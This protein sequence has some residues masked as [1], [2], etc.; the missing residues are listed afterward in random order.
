MQEAT[1][2]ALQGV[3]MTLTNIAAAIRE[4]GIE[5]VASGDHIAIIKHYNDLRQVNAI[6]KTAREALTEI[7]EKFS[8][9]Y[10]PDTMRA[11]GIKTIHLEGIGRVTINH[12]WSASMLDKERGMQWLRDTDN[13][14]LIIETVNS[15]TLASFAREK[16]EEEGV[17]LPNDIFKVG[18]MAYTSITKA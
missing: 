14:S 16:M 11:Q 1:L 15:S 3:T 2:A 4:E 8:R 13:G 12:R 17:D 9:E 5:T 18:Q 7:E 6:I 10:V